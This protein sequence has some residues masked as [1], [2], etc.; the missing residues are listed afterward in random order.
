MFNL[1]ASTRRRPQV[2]IAKDR[3]RASNRLA[4][5][6]LF[7]CVCGCST[8]RQSG[9]TPPNT[10]G[11]FHTASTTVGQPGERGSGGGGRRVG[12]LGE[13]ATTTPRED[14]K[15]AGPDAD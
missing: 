4:G 9:R 6:A 7:I 13:G 15:R 10:R 2:L 8:S 1:A 11:S 14:V 5:A 12:G 3:K